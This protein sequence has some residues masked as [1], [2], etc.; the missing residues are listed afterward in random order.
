MTGKRII[1]EMGT[2]ADLYGRDYTKAACRA[3]D[4]AI[5]H[6]SLTL[7]SSLGL[8]HETMQVMVTIGVQN[9]DAVDLDAVAAALPRGKA[10]V[11]AVLGGLDVAD[12]DKDGAHVIATAAIE[13]YLEVDPA[14]WRLSV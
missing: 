14:A 3:V 1:L 11:R 4:D 6:C 8:A 12:P 9:P 13:A 2:G 5:R 10:Q 7:F